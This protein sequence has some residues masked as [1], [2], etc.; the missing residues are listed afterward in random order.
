[1]VF[2]LR[3]VIQEPLCHSNLESDKKQRSLITYT[4]GIFI[5]NVN[6]YVNIRINQ[7]NL[8][9]ERPRWAPTMTIFQLYKKAHIGVC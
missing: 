4:N 3:K 2:E 7:E 8:T 9:T 1:M 5:A 6:K